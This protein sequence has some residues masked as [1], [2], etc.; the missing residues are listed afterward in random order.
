VKLQELTWRVLIGIQSLK[1]REKKQ[2]E[3]ESKN[4]RQFMETVVID[5]HLN[6]LITDSASCFVN[7][8][9]FSLSDLFMIV[10][11]NGGNS[12]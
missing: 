2:S 9:F 8:D 12:I 5:S 10:L 4:T 3:S 1:C 7:Q 11:H 6:L